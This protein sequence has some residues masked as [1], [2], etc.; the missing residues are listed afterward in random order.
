MRLIPGSRYYQ[1]R[2]CWCRFLVLFGKDKPIEKR[3][4]S[5]CRLKN[6]LTAYR[7]S[8]GSELGQ[9]V[10][11]SLGGMAFDYIADMDLPKGA[12]YIDLRLKGEPMVISRLP[13]L[14]VSDNDTGRMAPFSNISIRRC[15]IEFY[16][17]PKDKK[18][19]LQVLI[20]KYCEH[21]ND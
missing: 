20:R 3:I 13:S 21:L 17:P 10:D 16:Y 1:C 4:F 18:T 14:T 15:G 5:R 2:R 12:F 19:Q 9:V 6:G 7:S 11:I 8:D